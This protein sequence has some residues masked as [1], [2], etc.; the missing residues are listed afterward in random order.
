M[1][2]KISIK[3]KIVNAIAAHPKAI[4]LSVSLA[5]ATSLAVAADAS[6]FGQVAFAPMTCAHCN[7]YGGYSSFATGRGM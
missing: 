1:M 7:G 3:Q 5:I 2:E 6:H 4:T